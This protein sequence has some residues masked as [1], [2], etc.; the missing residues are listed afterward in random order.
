MS[1][2]RYGIAEWFGIP[3]EPLRRNADCLALSE[4]IPSVL[5]Q[6]GSYPQAAFLFFLPVQP[7]LISSSRSRHFSTFARMASAVAVRT[8][9]LAFSS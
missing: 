9:A 7:G 4:P 8:N 6:E 1:N 2:D 5:E 3:F